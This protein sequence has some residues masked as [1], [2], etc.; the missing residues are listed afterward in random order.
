[1][2]IKNIILIGSLIS[3]ILVFAF[4]SIV[5]IGFNKVAEEN[6]R[7]LI[8]QKV[9]Q[10]VSEL[11]ILLQEYLT[12]R[13]ERMVQQWNLNYDITNEI[14]EKIESEEVKTDYADLKYLFLEIISNYESKLS[15]E[16]E[17]RLVAQFL[18]KSQIIIS[19]C[20]I[21]A[22]DS[23]NNAIEAQKKANI[24]MLIYLLFLFPALIGISFYVIGRITKP[25]S[26]LTKG[27]EIIGMGN[28]NH[29][30]DIKSKDEIGK[31][32]IAFNDM[33]LKV[34]ERTKELNE[35][36]RLKDFFIDIM[37]HDL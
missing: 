7:E 32:A 21:T 6:E 30:I 27:T 22:E 11:N 1:M 19:D 20:S 10:T 9:H 33:A 18:I 12:Y 5:Y 23:Y 3:I 36:N 34:S 8:A 13:E 37:N 35:S 14:I 31:L 29:R 16:I 2:K 15:S 17:G 24:S 28:L 4:S 26:K 25:L